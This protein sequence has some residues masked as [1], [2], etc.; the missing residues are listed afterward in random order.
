MKSATK[1]NQ[2]EKNYDSNLPQFRGTI[3]KVFCLDEKKKKQAVI[4]TGSNY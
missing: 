1:K 4:E 3:K 2:I